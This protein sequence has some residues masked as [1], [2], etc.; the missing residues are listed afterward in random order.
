[1][2]N[3]AN[4]DTS[5]GHRRQPEAQHRPELAAV[6]PPDA[7]ADRVAQHPPQAEQDDRRGDVVAEHQPERALVARRR[8]ASTV[9]ATVS[10]TLVS[11]AS[12]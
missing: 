7:D 5:A 9:S 2:K 4:T 10:A 6:D 1:M 12:A 8:R 3:I 11:D